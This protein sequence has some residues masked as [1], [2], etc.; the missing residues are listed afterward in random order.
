M[1]SGESE[2]EVSGQGSA[3]QFLLLIFRFFFDPCGIALFQ[4]AL[5]RLL[6]IFQS[7][8][9]ANEYHPERKREQCRASLYLENE[10]LLRCTQLLPTSFILFVFSRE[11][12]PG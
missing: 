10:V 5:L 3:L 6:Q 9:V 2:L 1:V 4:C 12:F 8:F 11:Q 7:I